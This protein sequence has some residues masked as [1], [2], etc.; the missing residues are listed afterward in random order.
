MAYIRIFD[1]LPVF[2]L[3][4]DPICLTFV[5]TVACKDGVETTWVHAQ[6]CV[7]S[8]KKRS[9]QKARSLCDATCM[10]LDDNKQPFAPSIPAIFTDLHTR[11]YRCRCRQ[12]SAES[13][14]QCNEFAKY[15]RN[16]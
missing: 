13:V 6:M 4:V 12:C 3:P 2:F 15:Y 8:P 16:F 9:P 1:M 10:L 14:C 5:F 7:V 11:S